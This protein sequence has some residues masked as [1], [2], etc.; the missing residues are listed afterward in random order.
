MLMPSRGVVLRSLAL[1][2]AL[3]ATS[4]GVA[5]AQYGG[6]P[7]WEITAFNGYYV[8]SDLYTAFNGTA[9]NGSSIGLSN[10]YMWGGRLGYNPN[11]RLG[12]EFAYTRTGSDVEIKNGLNGFNPGSLGRINGNSYDLNFLFYQQSMGNPRVN[13]FFNLG[14]GWTVTDP[15]LSSKGGT[16][17]PT[18]AP[19][20]NTLFSWN[21]GLGAK[22]DLNEKFA[23]RLDARWRVTDTAITT[24]SGVYCDYYGWCYSYA[25]DWYNSGEFTAGLTFKRP[26]RR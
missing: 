11:P 21:M 16:I 15:E 18:N 12:V 22:V 25:S 19:E 9:G 6:G 4:A 23:L 3:V 13:G 1:A 8:A 17:T 2:G 20:G 5:G 14:F 7:S 24:S 10:S 26:M